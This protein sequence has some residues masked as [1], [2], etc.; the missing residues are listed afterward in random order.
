MVDKIRQGKKLAI[1]LGLAAV[2][3]GVI[4]YSGQDFLANHRFM[5]VLSNSMYPAFKQGDLLVVN[6][7]P[8]NYRVGDVITYQDPRG[9]ERLITHRILEAVQNPPAKMYL[10][11]GDANKL[12]DAYLVSAK[13]IV[14][15]YKFKFPYAGHLINVVQTRWGFLILWSVPCGVLILWQIINT[16]IDIVKV[17]KEAE[18]RVNERIV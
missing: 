4:L 2:V 14:G 17:R 13:L 12:P 7:G 8:R 18:N 9:G 15:L 1:M 10:T 5:V 3:I 11:K 6:T 16:I